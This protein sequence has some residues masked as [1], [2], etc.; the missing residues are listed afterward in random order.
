V[1]GPQTNLFG[2]LTNINLSQ[3]SS[4]GVYILKICLMRQSL[5]FFLAGFFSIILLT[6]GNVNAQETGVLTGEVFDVS[7]SE[8]LP[9]A[10]VYWEKDV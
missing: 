10:N 4:F 1:E 6:V 8:P 7:N 2:E 5:R 9:G 3:S